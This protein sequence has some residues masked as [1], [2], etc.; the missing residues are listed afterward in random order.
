MS[1]WAGREEVG[2]GD[3]VRGIEERP[4]TMAS[5]SPV[6]L[7]A[8]LTSRREVRREVRMWSC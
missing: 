6:R 5:G 2:V 7:Q 8:G 3:S 1:A 4:H